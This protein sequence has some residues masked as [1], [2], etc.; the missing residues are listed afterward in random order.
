MCADLN[1]GNNE[2]GLFG[3]PGFTRRL[4]LNDIYSR[5]ASSVFRSRSL[6]RNAFG[7]QC[8]LAQAPQRPSLTHHL[9]L[10]THLQI[11]PV[12]AQQHVGEHSPVLPS[13]SNPLPTHSLRAAAVP[14]ETNRGNR[15]TPRAKMTAATTVPGGGCGLSDGDARD[16]KDRNACVYNGSSCRISGLSVIIAAS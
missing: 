10:Q 13:A 6:S 9:V 15:T 16:V 4:S 14:C 8:V 12:F 11:A 2:P 3:E 7:Q 1:S 5:T